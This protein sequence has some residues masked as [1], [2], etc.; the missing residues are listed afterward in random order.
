MTDVNRP[1]VKVSGLARE[2]IPLASEVLARAFHDDPV[3][4]YM[5]P[6]PAYR[7]ESEESSA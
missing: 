2:G 4:D 1:D 6:D 5:I 7:I 3:T